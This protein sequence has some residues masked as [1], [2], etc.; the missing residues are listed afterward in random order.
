MMLWVW[1]VNKKIEMDKGIFI[2]MAVIAVL[3][4]GFTSY[5]R[6]VFPLIVML[7]VITVL[8]SQSSISSYR[9]LKLN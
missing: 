8:K 2:A 3:A 1:I 7:P 4:P 5:I 9:K 6:Y